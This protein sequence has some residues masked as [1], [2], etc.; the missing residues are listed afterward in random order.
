MSINRL[1]TLCIEILKGEL[2][3]LYFKDFAIRCGAELLEDCN[4]H[5]HPQ[6]AQAL[7]ELAQEG[8]IIEK[9]HS[10]APDAPPKYFLP[11]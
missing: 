8:K 5:T 3:G 4:P 9:R 1:K 7:R 10:Q 6:I 2:Q 11:N